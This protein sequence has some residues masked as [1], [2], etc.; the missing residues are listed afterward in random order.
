MIE[1]RSVSKVFPDAMV[2]VENFSTVLPSH[3]TTVLVGSSGCGRTTLLRMI[4]RMVEPTSGQV[5]IDSVGKASARASALELLDRW[6]WTALAQRY[7][8]QAH[9]R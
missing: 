8:R 1:F 6:G 3:Q 9:H 7:P 2:A 5:L 4:N